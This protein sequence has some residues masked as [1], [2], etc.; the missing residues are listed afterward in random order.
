MW[1]PVHFVAKSR[2]MPEAELVDFAL[3]NQD[4]YGIEVVT[5]THI[6]VNNWYVD[7]MCNDFREQNT[8]LCERTRTE[9]V[10][11]LKKENEHA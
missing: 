6:L 5:P 7:E 8:E 4:K 2:F 10:A 1:N 3:K 11:A 9:R